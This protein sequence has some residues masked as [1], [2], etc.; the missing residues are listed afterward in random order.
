MHLCSSL[1]LELVT[2]GICARI[3]YIEYLHIIYTYSVRHS[4]FIKYES[5]LDSLSEKESKSFYINF[6]FYTK[7]IDNFTLCIVVIQLL[8]CSLLLSNCFDMVQQYISKTLDKMV[9]TRIRDKKFSVIH[10]SSYQHLYGRLVYYYKLLLYFYIVILY[11]KITVTWTF[12]DFRTTSYLLR[13][14]V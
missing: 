8:S 2:I 1:P 10:V 5:K 3:N 4:K 13:F 12:D 7:I 14:D 6:N 9:Q 11:Y